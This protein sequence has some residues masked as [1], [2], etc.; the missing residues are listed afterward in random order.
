MNR[1]MV[2]KA[3]YSLLAWLAASVVVAG[4]ADAQ[5]LPPDPVEVGSL[6]VGPLALNPRFEVLNVGIDSNIFNEEEG[7]K[8]DFTATLR[9]GL[10]GGLRLGR[11]RFT[12]RGHLDVVYFQQ[13]TNERALNRSGEARAELRLARIVPYVTVAGAT[14]RERPNSEIDL[15]ARRAT[16]A[17][18]GGATVLLLS[19]TALVLGAERQT[20]GYDAGQQFGGEDLAIQLNGTREAFEGGFRL[21]LTP[22]TTLAL[23]GS[24]ERVRFEFSPD[25]DSESVRI[26]NRFEFDPT[27][28][29]TGS[30]A[31]GYRRFV[32][33]NPALQAFRGIVAQVEVRYTML[34]RTRVETRFTRDVEYSFDNDQ[35][36]YVTTGGN[37]TV[38]QQIRGPVDVQVVAG[39]ERLRYQPRTDVVVDAA[40]L[41]TTST[42]GGGFGYRL[43]HTARLGVNVE[44]TDRES[45]RTGRSYERRRIFA[46]VTYRF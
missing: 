43:G 21:A 12:Y 29:V 37:L 24:R 13:Y 33:D 19:R 4:S 26:M 44:F 9:P 3:R 34:E 40:G 16:Y 25:R 20:I 31:I 7:P 6:Q 27:A 11:A 32:P 8:E 38:T 36:Y 39:R 15:R 1:N 28:I 17:L 35:P 23:V 30:A 2:S 22:L 46:S 5:T 14:T 18:G 41:D 10:D 45:H 42:I